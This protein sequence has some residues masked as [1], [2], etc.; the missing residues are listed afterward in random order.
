[1]RSTCILLAFVLTVYT[2]NSLLAQPYFT[3][4]CTPVTLCMPAG[5]CTAMPFSKTV[6]AIGTCNGASPNYTW[7]LDLNNDV[8]I[9]RLGTGPT[10]SDTLPAGTH[11]V[12]FRAL[13]ACFLA[14]FC[15]II[16]TV[17]DC[18]P[19][20]M[21]S[22]SGLAAI[23]DSGDSCRLRLGIS[24]YVFNYSDNC[25]PKNQIQLRMRRAGTGSGFPTDT[26]VV[27]GRCDH[28]TNFI[29]LWARDNAGNTNQTNV[30]A[31][32]QDPQN[33][34]KCDTISPP[35][36]PPPPPPTTS[37]T[38]GCVIWPDSTAFQ[39]LTYSVNVQMQGSPTFPGSNNTL[40]Q[41]ST[42]CYTGTSAVPVSSNVILSL[43][44]L[45]SVLYEVNL[46]DALLIQRH[47]LG[48][49]PLTSR[50]AIKAAD[51]NNSNSLTSGDVVELRKLMLGATTQLPV[52]SF[53]FFSGRVFAAT[54]NLSA[55]DTITTT[56]MLPS[57]F[58]A[59][60]SGNV[61]KFYRKNLTAPLDRST[62][63]VEISE[64]SESGFITLTTKEHNLLGLQFSLLYDPKKV[65]LLPGQ[66]PGC[67]VFL[68][69]NGEA[70][71]L[72]QSVDGLPNQ[73]S[74]QLPARIRG[75]NT[76]SFVLSPDYPALAVMLH[77]NE[78]VEQP[79]VIRQHVSGASTSIYP[80]P[81]Y[82]GKPVYLGTTLSE[83]KAHSLTTGQ[84]TILRTNASG[85]LDS[86]SLSSG[87]YLLTDGYRTHKLMVLD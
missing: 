18:T 24:S 70:R 45:D 21:T 14:A 25:T 72:I 19:P 33:Q 60:K 54:G 73:S 12:V 52:P 85:W 6:T 16:V 29:E 64:P 43:T 71:I 87:V 26:S 82:K 65:E 28:G 46:I 5:A 57:N 44:K 50:F 11:R 1:M 75:A 7:Q 32:V 83:V 55:F 58:F 59:I 47:I 78:L 34:C 4:D 22:I 77:E 68:A 15:E 3:S 17:K 66:Y 63:E 36:P 13:D 2:G 10:F 31:L 38:L 20:N 62:I 41:F 56:S 40:G 86:S 84:V 80:N 35:P 27:F 81:V 8:S 39:Q 61:D 67:E 74:W 53:Q 48:L 51:V 9:N 76:G 49:A 30:Y 37:M 79:I 23:L 42:S 69:A